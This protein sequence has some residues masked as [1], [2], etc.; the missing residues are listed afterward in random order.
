MPPAKLNDTVRVHYT[1][2]L[3]D[4][5]V[6]DTS[7]GQA[8]LEFVLGKRQMI[9]GFEDA[10]LGMAPGESREATLPPEQAY[11][12]RQDR[13]IFEVERSRFPEGLKPELGQRLTLTGKD[14]G[15]AVVTVVALGERTVTL[16]G[17]HP[18]AGQALTFTIQL[19][20]ILPS[21]EA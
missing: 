16:D 4:G 3:A 6:F 5:T 20:E 11:G 7:S 2:K 10:V 21:A 13:L 1:G 17:N 19:V 15:T 18:L 9:T 14:G 8:P 12:P